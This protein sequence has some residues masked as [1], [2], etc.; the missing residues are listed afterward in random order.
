M[1]K[2]KGCFGLCQDRGLAN[3]VAPVFSVACQLANLSLRQHQRPFISKLLIIQLAD[4]AECFQ[5]S[6]FSVIDEVWLLIRYNTTHF[7][8][9]RQ[10]STCITG[11][12]QNDALLHLGK[13]LSL[14]TSSLLNFQRHPI[15]AIPSIELHHPE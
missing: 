14:T 8:S 4:F 13:S 7:T 11:N 10:L 2:S 3:D 1:A 6:D 12:R 5:W 9:S 15:F